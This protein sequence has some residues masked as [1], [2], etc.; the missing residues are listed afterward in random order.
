MSL[1]L[2]SP[3]V[4]RLSWRVS[5]LP[6]VIQGPRFLPPCF[7]PPLKVWPHGQSWVIAISVFQAGGR[8]QRASIRQA[9]GFKVG[10]MEIASVASAYV[11]WAHVS[12]VAIE[13]QGSL[14]NVVSTWAA[15][16]PGKILLLWKEGRTELGAV[17][18]QPAMKNI[19]CF[20][21]VNAGLLQG[22]C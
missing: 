1:S 14:G 5:R 11:P 15:V 19:S 20:I 10:V 3:Q 17:N 9:R 22:K 16:R 8:R 12:D 4:S 7:L 21:N 2:T 13:L 18:L 6:T